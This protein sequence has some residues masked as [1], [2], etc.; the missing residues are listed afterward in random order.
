M[1]ATLPAAS[2]NQTGALHQFVQ[3]LK[4]LDGEL[5]NQ[6]WDDLLAFALSANIEQ[7]QEQIN[8]P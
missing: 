1:P 8:S 2:E 5:I 3:D 7:G 4:T 6:I